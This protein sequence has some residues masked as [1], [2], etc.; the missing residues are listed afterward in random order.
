MCNWK[1]ADYVRQNFEMAIDAADI[2]QITDQGFIYHI[3]LLWKVNLMKHHPRTSS[4]IP[5][6]D[7]CITAV[8]STK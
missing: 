8:L 1:S 3:T 7:F 2:K 5:S 4:Q 6:V